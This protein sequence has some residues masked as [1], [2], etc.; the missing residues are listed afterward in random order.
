VIV[1]LL[2]FLGFFDQ[3]CAAPRTE[4]IIFGISNFT[5]WADFHVS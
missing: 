3:T 4:K 5:G 2:F 1:K